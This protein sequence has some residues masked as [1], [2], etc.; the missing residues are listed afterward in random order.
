MP[1]IKAAVG[2]NATKVQ[3]TTRRDW[4]VLQNQSDSNIYVAIDGSTDVTIDTGTKPGI[5]LKPGQSLLSSDIPGNSKANDNAIYAV[6][7]GSGSKTLT[8][9]YV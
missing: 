9:Q 6:H 4:F 7:D 2:T 1:I 5:K 3:D 8:L